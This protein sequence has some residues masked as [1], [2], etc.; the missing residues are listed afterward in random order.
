M[1]V[2]S[3]FHLCRRDLANLIVPALTLWL[4][5]FQLNRVLAQADQAQL[6]VTNVA[7]LHQAV[8]QQWR[9][10][11]DL[12]LTGTVCSV[13][14][15]RGVMVFADDTGAEMFVFNFDGQ[16][17][18][19]GQRVAL[20][21]SNCEAL[22]RRTEIALRRGPLVD[23]DGVHASLEK[24]GTVELAAGRHPM[25]VEWFNA[26]GAAILGVS[27]AA[28]GRRRGP[29]AVASDLAFRC[30]EGNWNSLPD[31][32]LFPVVKSGMAT[33]FDVKLTPRNDEVALEFTG[34]FTVPSDGQY[35][36]FLNSDDGSR[37]YVGE[38]L[39]R[40]AVLGKG[41]LPE[42]RRRLIGQVIGDPD[43]YQWALAEG[44]AYY[45]VRRDGRLELELQSR[46]G[47]RLE[48]EIADATGLAPELLLNGQVQLFG[49]SRN[50]QI[51]GGQKILG[52]LSVVSA[53]DVQL[54]ELAPEAWTAYPTICIADL[55]TRLR[56]TNEE[57]VV[58]LKGR[59]QAEA[60][61]Q[62]MYLTDGTGSVMVTRNDLAEKLAG[63]EV[64]VIGVGR[65]V[66]TNL[67]LSGICARAK[68]T[69]DEVA[70]PLPQ[71][72]TAE[73]IL[74]LK[75]E[76]ARHGYP[77]RLRGVVTCTWPDV[78]SNLILQDATRG[79]FLLQPSPGIS[80]RPQIGEFWEAE[81]ATDAGAF[82][83]IVRARKMTRL[84]EGRLPL[85]AHPD[86]DQLLNGSLDSQF[87]EIEGLIIDLNR[88]ESQATLMTHWGK[89]SVKFKGERLPKLEQFQNKLV[90]IRGCLLAVWD[91]V[92]HQLKV[93]EI[94]LGSATINADQTLPTDPFVAP[95]KS[96]GELLRYDIQASKFQR[97]KIS[98]QIVAER[99]GEF[100]LLSDG[101]GAR[102]VPKNPCLFHPGD[103][104]E[105][106]GIPEL[107]GPSP[108][109]REASARK[110]G[111]APLPAAK[112]IPAAN[113]LL[114]ENDATRVQ[115]EGVLLNT[116][117]VRDEQMLDLQNGSRI[118]SARLREGAWF[119][120]SMLPGTR[121]ELTGVYA[122][123]RGAQVVGRSVDSFE[124]L[125][126][127]SRD[128]R[129]LAR[130]PWWTLR[131][132]LAALGIVLVMLAGVMLWVFQLRRRV[133]IQTKIIHENVE[134]AAT[135]E[136]RTR[137]ARELHDTM[138]QALAGINFQLGAL[139]GTLRGGAPE[140]QQILERARLMARH[141]QAEARRTVRNLRMF[142]LERNNLSGALEQLAKENASGAGTKIEVAV[143]G[144]AVLLPVKVE[145]HLLRI[146]QEAITNA[147]KHAQAH[148][149]KI[150]LAYAAGF[151]QLKITDD[152]SGFD[153]ARTAPTEAGHFGLLG[154]RE[155]TDKLGGTLKITS[156][157]GAGT[158]VMVHVPWSGNGSKS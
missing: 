90:R 114:T 70:A 132:S 49:V 55:T 105:V 131:R 5:F 47:N 40:V 76:E 82:S 104:V 21:G 118:F 83:P 139:A 61:G 33:N 59:L 66:G 89:V 146:G 32:D 152:G 113:F 41:K 80:G 108:V 18:R 36:F 143:S 79:I 117:L 140:A 44:T 86:W 51:P 75:P 137:I 158:T 2:R 106:A 98:G 38:A 127:S 84:G 9:V 101:N 39:P 155:R 54:R 74:R 97:V 121:L 52:L 42:L 96:I 19:A 69:E 157:P 150:E 67:V 53:A 110:T 27:V 12:A 24:S 26:G 134:H 94:C 62:S 81:G 28:P 122:G 87:V 92:T 115:M 141:A 14:A 100:F 23:N 85:P 125:L 6:L 48:A 154:M 46:T 13:S 119:L 126:D 138:E 22:R 35:R 1:V 88:L 78:F 37:L 144:Q 151:V 116:R 109:L 31:F 149:I 153:V 147:L 148:N 135:L 128:V 43:I 34:E 145:N 71:L 4:G 29:L 63:G 142:A 123:Q 20:M 10:R 68:I 129:V 65:Q 16:Q 93:G 60:G 73:Q 57:E 8:A 91:L 107:G 45:A 56:Q 7:Q 95:L 156:Q 77:V 133:E 136:E 30:I 99:A 17:V 102:F 15:A 120:L 111:V 124:L 112:R 58:H 72:T 103:M 50:V 11:C 3:R 25:R 64:E 130:P